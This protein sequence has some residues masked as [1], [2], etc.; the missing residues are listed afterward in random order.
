MQTYSMSAAV[1]KDDT[2]V[3][4]FTWPD[5][6]TKRLVRALLIAALILAVAGVISMI[7][8]L[9]RHI[10]GTAIVIIFS[11]LFAYAVYPPIKLISRRGVPIVISAVLVYIVLA[12]VVIGA[13]AWL[14]PAI[15]S[16]LTD[17]THNFPRI[18]TNVQSQISNPT[19][20]PLLQKLPSGVRDQIAANAGKAGAAVSSVAGAVG[21]NALGILAGTTTT[22][23]DVFLI[24]TLTLL[25]IGDLAEIQAF[26]IRL[27]PRAQRPLMLSFMSEVDQVIG[28]FVRGQ[29]VVA[30][31]VAVLA[32]LILLGTGVPYAILIGLVA[33]ILS[34]VPMVGPF[35][36]ILPV[37][38]VAF[39][40]VGFVK[41]IVVLVLFGI[42]IA[43]QQ[44]V[45]PLVNARTVGVTPL[46]VFVA[47][48]IGSEAYGILGA[49]L[50]IPVAGIL[51]VAAARLFPPDRTADTLLSNARDRAGEPSAET[52]EA[53][54]PPA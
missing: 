35:I 37:V 7:T 3:Q 34:I 19:Q 40:T 24:L 26:G 13:I 51:R 54:A 14:A 49:L 10:H 43:I 28:G 22:V 44:N 42:V 17:L 23:V 33:G 27:V 16:Q 48:L 15:A 32:T 8:G 2:I 18:V 52:R 1:T 53:T 12:L 25:I 39:F 4:P 5:D 29:L 31:G 9:F 50:S 11:I 21:G 20:S 47:L 6:T 30:F 45:L 46:V 38:A 41:A 36:A